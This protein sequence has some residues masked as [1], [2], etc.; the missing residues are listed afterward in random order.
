MT[1]AIDEEDETH[2]PM[3]R[4]CARQ[5]APFGS[6]FISTI[7]Q[8]A[9]QTSLGNAVVARRP[10]NPLPSQAAGL[11]LKEPYSRR[12]AQL[13]QPS[14][15]AS[16]RFVLCS[17][18]HSRPIKSFPRSSS[19]TP[20]THPAYGPSLPLP[21]DTQPF[22]STLRITIETSSSIQYIDIP[23]AALVAF[24]LKGPTEMQHFPSHLQASQLAT[25]RSTRARNV[26]VSMTPSFGD[27]VHH[28]Y[29]T[30]K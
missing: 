8:V 18:S 15:A 29:R 10:P 6:A 27:L 16:G 1:E 5:T 30:P 13:L 23:K 3:V 22:R 2:C 9:G 7:T 20:F 4:H 12:L 17:D 14:A 25:P 24:P 26:V 21:T 19:H 11:C 28:L